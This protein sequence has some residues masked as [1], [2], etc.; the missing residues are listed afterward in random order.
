MAHI[1]QANGKLRTR[2]TRSCEIAPRV[3][4]AFFAIE[5]RAACALLRE[6]NSPTETVSDPPG[7]LVHARSIAE[8]AFSRAAGA[9]LVGGNAL[10]LLLDGVENYA[11]WHDAI[12][13]AKRAIYFENYIIRADGTGRSFR[14]ALIRRAADGV[15]VRLLLDWFGSLT[16][17]RS[18]WEPLIRAGGR[19]RYHNPPHIRG[20]L[21]WLSRDH[22]KS[23]VVDG[24]VG[25]ISGV[26]VSDVW[27]G[28][29][30]RGIEPY[31]DTGVELRGPAVADLVRAF[32]HVWGQNGSAI[33]SD[34]IAALPVPARAGGTSVRV[35]ATAPNF[36]ALYRLDL[37]VAALAQRRL[38]LT[39]AYFA[40]TASYMHALRAAARDGVDVRLLVPGGS[41]L[42]WLR[43]L[44]TAGRCSM[45]EFASSSGTD[46]C[47]TPRRRSPTIAGH[48][49]DRRISTWRA[50]SRTSNWML[51]LM[52][53]VSR[54]RWPT[55]MSAI[56]RTRLKSS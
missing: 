17:P 21:N 29:A 40:G 49:W 10:R 13:A 5:Q 48:G 18:F 52:T 37:L 28:D 33:P 27:L 34:E 19:V 50:G 23:L 39:D 30:D 38:W 9:P 47:C 15:K 26:C 46:R 20:E 4:R 54:A 14:D 8:H 22:R 55:C 31:R 7:P 41:D 6:L 44:T 36:T 32:T 12:R 24:G 45:R 25:F 51:P 1:A 11:A 56:S 43:P 53:K 3:L 35:V 16:T 42:P 2:R